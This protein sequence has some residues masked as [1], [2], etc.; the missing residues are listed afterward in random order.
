[1][2]GDFPENLWGGF[3]RYV[4]HGI[5][6]GSFLKAFFVGDF[7]E[8]CRRG[9]EESVKELWPAVVYLHNQCPGGCFGSLE[10]VRD[11]MGQGGLVGL[12]SAGS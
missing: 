7:H 6:P 12:E 8:L 3:K 11:W 5:E 10:H 4:L 2:S 9:G 1:M